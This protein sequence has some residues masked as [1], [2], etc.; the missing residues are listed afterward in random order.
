[1]AEL[2]MLSVEAGGHKSLNLQP[3]IHKFTQPQIQQFTT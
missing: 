3:K 1:M 2:E